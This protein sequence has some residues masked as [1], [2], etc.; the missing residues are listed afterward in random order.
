MQSYI[1]VADDGTSIGAWLAIIVGAGG[2]QVDQD[3]TSSFLPY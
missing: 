3:I 2:W 1:Q